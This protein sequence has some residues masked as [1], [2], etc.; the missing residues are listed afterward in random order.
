MEVGRTLVLSPSSDN[1]MFKNLKI[2]E[3]EMWMGHTGLEK[4]AAY[5]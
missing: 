2:D 4:S 5:V 1:E 3:N